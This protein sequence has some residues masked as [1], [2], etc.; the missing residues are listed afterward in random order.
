MPVGGRIAGVTSDNKVVYQLKWSVFCVLVF[1]FLAGATA[2][3]WSH[4]LRTVGVSI[5]FI[6]LCGLYVGSII[7]RRRAATMPVESV[8]IG[9]RVWLE[10]FA[11]LLI[12]LILL[13]LGYRDLTEL[14]LISSI[15]DQMDRD[16]SDFL[17]AQSEHERRFLE[18]RGKAQNDAGEMIQNDG[19]PVAVDNYMLPEGTSV[20]L[21]DEV[22]R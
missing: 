7:V 15:G 6:G 14:K 11:P 4:G 5:C 21:K 9:W 1:V 8:E 19:H 20:I 18:K 16:F 2:I 10:I 3:W 13:L 22:V 17:D 12:I